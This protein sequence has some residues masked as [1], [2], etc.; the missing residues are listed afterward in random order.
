MGIYIDSN[1]LD[2]FLTNILCKNINLNFLLFFSNIVLYT[3]RVFHVLIF[4][5]NFS[6]V[7]EAEARYV[8][9][10][11]RSA[12]IDLSLVFLRR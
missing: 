8:K 9:H 5:S 7:P 3:H 12:K 11:C 4:I 6:L 1:V 10:L 2:V